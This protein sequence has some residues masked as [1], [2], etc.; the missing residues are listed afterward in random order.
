MVFREFIEYT[1]LFLI[2]TVLHIN[3]IL[4]WGMYIENNDMKLETS[5]LCMTY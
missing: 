4:C 2:V 3:F 1:I 5:L